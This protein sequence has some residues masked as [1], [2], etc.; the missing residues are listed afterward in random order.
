ELLAHRLRAAAG[1]EL[2]RPRVDLRLLLL[3]A[4]DAEQRGLHRLLGRLAEL[5]AAEAAEVVRRVEQAEQR[6]RLLLG[7]GGG[8]E[9]VAREVGEA[10]LRLRRELPRE[11]EVDL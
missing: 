8:V 4:L 2:G 1:D 3:L 9:V 5:A 10:E 11:V 7:A 6:R